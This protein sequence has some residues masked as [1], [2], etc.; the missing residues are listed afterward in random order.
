MCSG[1]NRTGTLCGKCVDGYS[2]TLNSPTFS[3]NKC[4][5]E[6]KLG[7]FYLLLSYI[8]PVSILFVLIMKYDIRVTTGPIGSFLFFSQ[9]ISS[10]FHYILIYFINTNNPTTLNIFN[11]ILGIYSISNLDFFNHDIFKYCIFQRAGTIDIVVFELLLS[12]Y[13]VLL[14][15]SYA[16]IRKYY[17]VCK[18][19]RCFRKFSFS[20][21]SITHAISAFLVICF[22]K[23]NLQAFT[24][25]IPAEV[26]YID[27]MDSLYK[28]VVYLQ[29]DLEYFKEMPHTLYALGAI[30]FIVTVIGIPIVIL[31]LHPLLMQIVVYFKWGESKPVLFI[32][33]CLMIDRLKP[34]LDA[35]Q[36]YCKDHL[37]FFAGLQI[38]FYRTLFFL[39]VVV[40]TPDIDEALLCITG[41]F[42]VILLIHCLAMP[43]KK[44]VDNAVYSMVYVLMLTMI[45][46][47]LYTI[48]SRMFLEAVIWLHIILCALPLCCFVSYYTWWLVKVIR[49][50]Y[51]RR[52]KTNKTMQVRLKMCS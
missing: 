44:Y 39:I 48:T 8:L 11:A 33:K 42:I 15:I 6:Y 35:F 40:T 30:V 13:P 47:E 5:D 10:E 26:T 52:F 19:P 18:Q 37:Q 17:Y 3:C 16:L 12:L 25:L 27:D 14:I 9:I 43:F 23:I 24:I 21:K 22:A 31:L 28:K 50:I 2:V 34:V 1:S 46:I 29:G 36:G 49:K 38:F 20:N 4:D 7:V 41:Y 51:D 32:N 45:V